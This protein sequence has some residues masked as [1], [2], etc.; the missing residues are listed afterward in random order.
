VLRY[1]SS[2]RREKIRLALLDNEPLNSVRP[3]IV[4]LNIISHLYALML[5]RAIRKIDHY[6]AVYKNHPL[7]INLFFGYLP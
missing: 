3:K 1:P 7:D 6:L 5:A 4:F 2:M